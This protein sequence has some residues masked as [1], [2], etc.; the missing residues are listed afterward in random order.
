MRTV[1]W[2]KVEGCIY[3]LQFP[4]G[5]RVQCLHCDLLSPAIPEGGTKGAGALSA[6]IDT[7]AIIS[8][9]N[10][11]D[12]KGKVSSDRMSRSNKALS[13]VTETHKKWKLLFMLAMVSAER[14][15][16]MRIHTKSQLC[17]LCKTSS[18]HLKVD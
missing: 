2:A 18:P 9:I 12:S 7:T 8:I 13:A 4:Q 17:E 6:G 5:E 14:T 11:S 16:R 15:G 3:S 1:E 10:H